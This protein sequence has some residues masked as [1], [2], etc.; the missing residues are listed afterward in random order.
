MKKT[1]KL[2]IWAF[3]TL[4][5]GTQLLN[6]QQKNISPGVSAADSL[7]RM[8][9]GHLLTISETENVKAQAS[10][11][12]STL[13]KTPTANITNTLYGRLPG[14][15]VLQGSGEPGYDAAS[16]YIRGLGTYDNSS[17][18]IYVDGFQTTS[19][20]FQYLSPAEIESV[21]VLKDAAA[22]ASFGMKGAN[23]VLWVVTKRGKAG[24]S[25]VAVN[26]VSG[27]QQ[28]M[29]IDKPLGAYD[30]ARL[31]N[32][33]ISNDNYSLNGY[34]FLWTPKYNDK[35]LQAY[36]N[37]SAT[38]VEWFDQV[39]RKNAPYTDAN[40]NFNGGNQATK[41]MVILDYMNQ[42]GIY[43]IAN[44]AATSN[45][46]IQRFNIRT[47]LDL[48]FFKI[49]EA[50]IDLGGRIEDRHY[51]NYNGSQ[52]WQNL[53]TYPSNIYPVRDSLT[54]HWSG[55][56]LYPNN[57]VAT[58]HG[59]GWIGT[60]DRTLQANFGLKERLDFITP[61]L[62]LKEA[63]SLNTWTRNA[64]SYTATYARYYNGLQTTT[65]KQAT[66]VA[67][68][69]SPV[70]QYD[71]KQGTLTAGYDRTFGKH[72][73][74]AAV[75]YLAS[76]FMTDYSTNNPGLNTGN[77]IFY[78]YENLGSAVHYAYNAKYLLDINVGY[79]GSDSY[80]PGNRWKAYPAIG[81]GWILS[82]ESF[83]KSSVLS[84]L[85]LRGSVGLSGNDQT[86]NGRY[87]YQQ[88]F[89]QNGTYYTGNNGLA[90]NNGTVQSY[91]AN[92]N[93]TAEKSL[94]YDIGFDMTLIQKLSV[95]AD[96]FLDKRSGIVT[97]TNDLLGTF[98]GSQP[99]LNIGKVTN[100]GFEV[101]ARYGDHVGKLNYNFGGSASFAKN[102]VDF[103][104]EIPTVNKFSQTTGL[105]IGIPVGLV[106]T[107]FYNITDF[108]SDGTL[109][110][111]QSLPAFG[112]VQPGDIKY[113]DLD[114]NGKIDQNDV[115]AIGKS[116]LPTL[117]YTFNA[118]VSYSGF[119]FSVQ[120]QGASGNSVN[121]LSAA[122]YQT[123]AFVNNINVYP[124]AQNAWAYFPAQGIDTR[125]TATYPRLSTLANNN[126]YRA[127]SF[128][129]VSGDYLRVR[130]AEFGYTFSPAL[131]R[132][133]HTESLRI[134]VSAVNPLT[135]SYL[136]KH[137]NIDPETTSGYPALKSYNLGLSFKF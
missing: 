125:A 102:T 15:T 112:A 133:I 67:N 50:R 77:N 82:E 76:N 100:K 21:T 3:I 70:N 97:K 62:Y 101:S 73:I 109:K 61:G 5:L 27:L 120:F 79:S 36:K 90:S 115:T 2:I 8:G 123:V 7:K 19:S 68:G 135:W 104:S 99:Y 30:Y 75:E 23:G 136:S 20:Y 40:V 33:A 121:L 80:A 71:W 118:E 35:Q 74:S 129:M 128:W 137:Y 119:D 42:G 10:V 103:Q 124:I 47:N 29:R 83:L 59:L 60:H 94:K 91:I 132:K 25:K 116:P 134:Y 66:I 107:G 84:F 114:G 11:S 24:P 45:A 127:S 113:K 108:N 98:G 110:T 51:P 39:L 31:Y 92:P 130:N 81:A 46:Q 9:D 88:Y 117:T 87:L 1:I 95:T 18:V 63:A 49:F 43:D 48:N 58:L 53:A 126:N 69:S 37:G 17:L 55:T 65:D 89:T 26:V 44:T 57:P 54:G 64:F 111:G 41:Y 131:L 14:L 22:L 52:L 78:H 56:A 105:A 38:N 85:K 34:Q 122:Y 13:Y 28:A 93:I 6:A 86:N 16:L 72:R 32:Q 4:P 96:V 106:S 12:G